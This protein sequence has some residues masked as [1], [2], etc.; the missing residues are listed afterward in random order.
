MKLTSTTI[1][2]FRSIEESGSVSIEP[3]VTVLVGQN[4]SGKTGFLEA[5][6]RCNSVKPLRKFD[7]IE[8]YPR[9]L[10]TKFQ[11]EK[12]TQPS[13]VVVVNS[14]RLTSSEVNAISSDIWTEVPAEL[15]FTVSYAYDGTKQIG[16]TVSEKKMVQS[17]IAGDSLRHLSEELGETETLRALFEKVSPLDLNA[18]AKT[19]IDKLKSKYLTDKSWQN[20]LEHYIFKAHLSPK[21]PQF[22]YFDE[23]KLLPGK[24]NLNAFQQRLASAAAN[25][26]ELSDEDSTVQSLLRM[27]GVSLTELRDPANYETIKAKLEGFSNEITDRVFKYWKQN[28]ELDVL[29]D[30]KADPKDQAPFN[31]GQ[32]LYIRIYNRRH[33]VSMPFDRRSKGFIWFFSFIVWFGSVKQEVGAKSDLILLLDEPGLSLHALAQ[34]DF[35]EYIEELSIEHQ[36]IYTTH[37]P[38]MVRSERLSEVRVVEDKDDAGTKVSSNLAGSDPKTLFPLQAA[39]GYTI[40]Q[41]LFIATRNLLVEGPSEL[42]YF[43][44]FSA[45]LEAAKRHPLREDVTIVPTGGL[46]KVATFVSLLGA[47]GLELV[48]VHDY[49][50]NNA[51]NLADLIKLKI[52]EQKKVRTFSEYRPGITKPGEVPSDVEDLFPLEMYVDRYKQDICG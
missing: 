18:S 7:E 12:A 1:R 42:L 14:Y 2:N 49:E 34:Q 46:D 5:L 31:D 36:V 20:L 44:H 51:Q 21:L 29:F 50:K 22:V 52:I 15:Q 6:D 8:D 48:V 40:A 23:Y 3:G 43:R 24:V 32:N 17:I 25:K 37:S 16:I 47:S 38:F 28:K 13:P 33:R 45:L 41:N 39:L 27:A 11:R 26:T 9:R 35:L 4:E 30:I 10:L 19:E